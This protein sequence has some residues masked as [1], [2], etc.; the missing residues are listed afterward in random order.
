M[1]LLVY[2][3]RK[4]YEESRP[5]A[6]DRFEPDTPSVAFNQLPAEIQAQASSSNLVHVG[7][8]RAHEAAK[9]AP[10]LVLWNAYAVILYGEEGVLLVCI[11]SDDDIAPGRAVLDGIVD[12]VTENL[13]DTT[14]VYVAHEMF[15]R[16]VDGNPVV[17]RS[18]LET[19]HDALHQ[20]YQVG[21]FKLQFQPSG[22]QTCH[23]QQIFGQFNK[24]A[25]C[26][27]NVRYGFSLPAC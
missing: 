11:K 7:V 21:W 13:L 20:S 17:L 27:V 23:V 26:L 10:V 1:L 3:Q 6:F 16:R 5:L 9:D 15:L 22:L 24:P 2:V 8:I 4:R 25:G 14:M 18:H 19:R 12:E